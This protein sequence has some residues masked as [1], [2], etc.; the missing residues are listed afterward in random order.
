MSDVI[1]KTI[2]RPKK[3][4][5]TDI[6]QRL[7][8]A[9]K[10]L[11]GQYGYESVSTRQIAETADTTPA[12]I[13][14]YFAN[15]Q[16]LYYT[17]LTDAGGQVQALLKAFNRDPKLE[18]LEQFFIGF[19]KCFYLNDNNAAALMRRNMASHQD[20]ELL[21]KI[22]DNGPKPAYQ[23]LV[24]ILDKLQLAK[25]V[26]ADLDTG[27]LAL[28]IMALCSYPCVFSPM[29]EHIMSKAV[30]EDFYL[31]LARQN[32]QVLLHSIQPEP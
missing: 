25:Q 15:K 18:H 11:F 26:K 30:D 23:L 9:A 28:Q 32:L 27:L 4:F 20:S 8:D 24:S 29:L 21:K 31:R 10:S 6:R 19:Y 12:M 7:F 16:G 17:V 14:Y 13:R 22:L 3:S 2:G 5:Q 1:E